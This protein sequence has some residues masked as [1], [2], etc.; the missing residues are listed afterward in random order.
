MKS[1]G[2]GKVKD[3]LRVQRGSKEYCS[4]AAGS[5]P[6]LTSA[7]NGIDAIITESDGKRRLSPHGRCCAGAGSSG[8]SCRGSVVFEWVGNTPRSISGIHRTMAI[9]TASHTIHQEILIS[10]HAFSLMP[11]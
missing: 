10:P 3:F 1:R 2:G 4:W 11:P 6:C 9:K 5:D 7:S 8:A